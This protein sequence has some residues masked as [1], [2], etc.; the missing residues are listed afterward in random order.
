[1]GSFFP[2]KRLTPSDSLTR[3]I[4]AANH[5]NFQK[6]KVLGAA[7]MPLSP[8]R[9]LETS[10]YK[11][12]GLNEHK[13]WKQGEKVGKV[14][15]R[16]LKARA[17]FEVKSV[18]AASLSVQPDKWPSRHANIIGWPSHEKKSEQMR[19]ANILALAARLKMP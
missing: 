8:P 3:F 19:L 6:N 18:N 2:N 7:F 5:F 13:I 14:S 11:T 16:N 17:D 15:K 10:I 9:N 4:F 12:K 1:L